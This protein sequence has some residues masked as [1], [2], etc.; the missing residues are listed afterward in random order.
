M[1]ANHLSEQDLDRPAL[2]GS[3]SSAYRPGVR[4]SAT[5]WRCSTIRA[6]VGSTTGKGTY[7]WDGLAG[8]WFWS[9]P[10]NDV[11]FIG[12][13]QRMRPSAGVAEHAEPVAR[14]G[15]PGARSIRQSSRPI[16]T[17]PGRCARNDSS[18]PGTSSRSSR[19]P[20]THSSHTTGVSRCTVTCHRVAGLEPGRRLQRGRRSDD[21]GWPSLLFQVP[22]RR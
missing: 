10:S 4:G 18:S 3:A 12:M 14:P 7:L 13:I 6:K 22:Q 16:G 5:T 15:A 17:G 9:D 1:R 8:T 19:P 11:V 20:S 21:R 2:S